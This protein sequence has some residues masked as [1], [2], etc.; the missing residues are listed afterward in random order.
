MDIL[1]LAERF[2]KLSEGFRTLYHISKHGPAKPVSRMPKREKK[3]LLD[4]FGEYREIDVKKQ[5]P[6]EIGWKR[7]WLNERVESGV[8]L[9]PNPIEVVKYHARFGTVHVYDVAES[10]IRESGGIHHYDGASEILIPENIWSKGLDGELIKYK[11]S[12]SESDLRDIVKNYKQK[13]SWPIARNIYLPLPN[14]FFETPDDDFDKFKEHLHD[15]RLKNLISQENATNLSVLYKKN[16]DIAIHK[17]ETL[18]EQN[19]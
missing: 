1:K 7:P 15:L 4:D 9:T 2:V 12:I 16:K 19:G 3:V 11:G 10:I 13:S 17:L 6:Q 5:S 18:L 8:F 14:I